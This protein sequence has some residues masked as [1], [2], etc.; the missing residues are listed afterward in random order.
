MHKGESVFGGNQA[1]PLPAPHP[2]SAITIPLMTMQP[3]TVVSTNALPR[4]AGDREEK[5]EEPPLPSLH[6]TVF[7]P[8]G[9]NALSTVQLTAQG[10]EGHS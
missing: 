2:G 9:G 10:W 5:K 4:L 3:S 8:E 6:S 7:I 1:Q